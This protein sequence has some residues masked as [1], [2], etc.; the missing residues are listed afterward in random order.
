MRATVFLMLLSFGIFNSHLQEKWELTKNKNGVKVYVRKMP[1]SSYYAFKALMFVN[2]K[3]KEI[4][5]LLRDVDQ[6]PKWFAYTSSAR[7]IN[8]TSKEQEF[9]METDYPWPYSNECMNYK[10]KF[11]DIKDGKLK[12]TITE[13]SSSTNCKH[14]LNKASGY[15]LLERGTKNLKITYYFHSEPSQNI[16]AW[17]IN[18]RIHEMPY[19]TFIS[20]RE[21]LNVLNQQLKNSN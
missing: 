6:Y 3:E 19:Q 17:L 8:Q 10:M 14:S 15:I 5:Q 2:S 18:P 4:V 7:L 20:M 9:F 11:F 13:S 16:P 12:I 1:D 21:K